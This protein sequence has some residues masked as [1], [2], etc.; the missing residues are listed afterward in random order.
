M[1][2]LETLTLQINAESQK[3]YNAI[4][5]LAQRLN[6]LSIS[7][8]QIETGKLNQLAFG[9]QNLSTVV[10]YM[11]G[12]TAKSDYKHIVTNISQLAAINTAGI[13]SLATSLSTLTSSMANMGAT[14]DV[15]DNISQLIL[16]IGK[17]GHKSITTAI[18]NIPRL[19]KALSHLITTFSRLPEVNQ[20]II[21]FVN[22]LSN[23]ASQ[24]SKV[25]T[26][27]RSIKGSLESFE[28]S[29]T[30]ATKKA[31]N[32]ASAI[33]KMYAEFWIAMRAARGLRDAFENAADY[34]EAYNY[35]DVVAEK[36][37]TDT[38]HK[39]GIGSADE[40][41]EAFTSEM[42]RKLKQMS[43]LELDL[44]DRIIKSTNAKSLG[45]NI[46]ELTQ[47]QASIASITNAMGQAQEVS[48]ATA[49][50]FS[51]LA[52]DM[53]SLKNID[54]DQVASNLQSALAGQARAIYK[55]GIDIT[56]ATLEQYAFNA[57]IE[58]SV[59]EMTQAE[60]AQLRL[61][62]ILDQSKVAWGDLANTINSPANQ[63]RQLKNNF[64]EV[65][66]VLG[67][68]FIPIMSRT[69]PWINGLSIAIK[70]L[71]VD[72]AG[73]L[74][75]QLNLDEF[76]K[77]FSDA[78]EEDTEALDDLN[79]SMKETKKGIREFDE[80]KVI[81]GDNSKA[82]SGLAD[83]IDL[84][85][86]ILAATE[87][88]E[89]VWDEAYRRMT[90]KAQ[91]IS[92]YI[93]KAFEPIKKIVEDFHIGDFF[94]AGKDVSGLVTS[95]FNFFSDAIKKV[96]WEQLGKNIGSFIEGIKWSEILKSVGGLIASA[97]Q[98]ALDVWKGAF[99]VAPFETAL[100]SAF[101]ILKF[102]GFG[103]I[104]KTGLGKALRKQLKKKGLSDELSNSLKKLGVL[105]VGISLA[106]TID[107]IDSIKSGDYV[108]FS[109]QSLIKSAISSL[110]AGAGLT[111]I[112]A[113]FGGGHLG[114][115]FAAGFGIS[116]LINLISAKLSE[117]EVNVAR[118]LARQQFEWV[119]EKHLDTIEVVTNIEMRMGEVTDKEMNLDWLAEQVINLSSSYDTLTDASKDLLKI[120]SDELIGM[121]PELA[122]SIDEVTGAYKGTREELEK[123]IETEK[124]HIRSQ[125][126]LQNLVDLSSRKDEAQ[127]TYD[128]IMEELE[129]NKLAYEEAERVLRDAGWKQ[130]AI[131]NIA[132]GNGK[133]QARKSDSKEIR[134]AAM[135]INLYAENWKEAER[136][137]EQT[138]YDLE[139]ITAR[140]DEY[141]KEYNE[142]IENTAEN[143]KDTLEGMNDES[144]KIIESPK[145]PNAI[146]K[147]MGKIDDKI[148][149]GKSVTTADMNKMFNSINDS[150]AGLG[151]GK[152]PE[153]VQAT[154]DNIEYAIRTNSPKLINYMA[155]LRQQMENAFV[156]AIFDDE[157]EVKWNPNEI[158]TRL[159]RDV[160]MI[161]SAV[162][163][164][165][166][167]VVGTIEEDLKELFGGSLPEEVDKSYKALAE[168]IEKGSG[169]SAV[170][171]ALAE[172]VKTFTTFAD[173]AGMN[174]DLSLGYS[175]DKYGNYVYTA[176]ESVSDGTETRYKRKNEM[177]S[178]SK[179]YKRLGAYI[180]EGIALGIESGE[181]EVDKSIDDI[182]A[183]I[184]AQFK[185]YRW[186]IPSMNLGR[187]SVGN[188]FNYGNMD[189]NNA[190]MT[191]MANAVNM[192]AANGQTE[193]VFRIEGD[194]HGMFTVM[195]EEDSSYRK[196]TGRSAFAN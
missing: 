4:D 35:F 81:G 96:D 148:K 118:E 110:L 102:T 87:E 91:E 185:D 86:Q 101:A 182:S 134:D 186:N 61:L 48:T 156:N 40:Y 94:K 63:L 44:E 129:R 181:R 122:G 154:M 57:G 29:A 31:H 162:M 19:E 155:T 132:S 164:N 78:M 2:D 95:I 88:Y 174:L 104:I 184:Q 46:T 33:G 126:L 189:A 167:P 82:G 60:K 64:K 10:E 150:F 172:L 90:S 138:R 159:G 8:A 103:D 115:V 42:K 45:L 120:Y 97:L 135:Y 166:K 53:G 5:K 140:Y 158:A 30:K 151:D 153:E 74:G 75:I 147:T 106:I 24:G 62:A 193:V 20:N 173:D 65:G 169:A 49:K 14:V 165:A 157:G 56:Q 47:Y 16:A 12:K 3:A 176:I 54:Y 116:L 73:I 15:A 127:K 131:D 160:G 125:A 71:L 121:M 123:L 142:I 187:P 9:L 149:E 50:V 67:Q 108:A 92:A 196:R 112:V 18:V 6:N 136:N 28:G 37:G 171:K 179:L 70:N 168:T 114:L 177:A 117:P 7:I 178:P 128:D 84:T 77:G 111:S 21:E 183:S 22:S 36:I 17:L 146:S 69:L 34:L 51:M 180:P 163:H 105:S 55:Y 89:K 38:F 170:K 124:R 72:I 191:Q 188:S 41:A 133:Y 99:S 13:D 137:L 119:Q 139:H 80:L 192:A 100:L 27:T 76:G 79:K 145:L 83:Q 113:G 39:A 144:A 58:K 195:R 107:N 93:S 32:L 190:F 66:V 109:A 68:L 59:S 141:Y 98:G 11:N 161:E 23:L 143:T 130:S 43:G 52:A 1:A 26:A 85:N 25:G 175:I 194:P 152:V